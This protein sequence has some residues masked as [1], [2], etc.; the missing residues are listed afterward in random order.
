MQQNPP[1]PVHSSLFQGLVLTEKYNLMLQNLPYF[2]NRKTDMVLFDCHF[3]LC[4]IFCSNECSLWYIDSGIRTNKVRCFS[5]SKN[6]GKSWSANCQAISSSINL[7]FLRIVCIPT[8]TAIDVCNGSKVV[9]DFRRVVFELT[10]SMAPAHYMS[11]I[12]LLCSRRLIVYMCTTPYTAV[13]LLP[14]KNRVL[15]SHIRDHML[16]LSLL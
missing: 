14:L 9:A 7:L 16:H 8:H 4:F 12:D 11:E 10:A 15:K 13:L 6:R 3:V 5:Y 2:W 1:A